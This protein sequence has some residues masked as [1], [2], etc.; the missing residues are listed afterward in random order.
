M[1]ELHARQPRARLHRC[2]LWL[3]QGLIL[4]ILSS[5][6]AAEGSYYRYRDDSGRV[7]IS[8]ILPPDVAPKGY[9]IVDA[10]GRVIS[11][12]AP[13]LT[14][15][16]IAERDARLAREAAEEAARQRQAEADTALLTQFPLPQDAE[17]A[18]ERR[19]TELNALIAFKQS[20][21]TRSTKKAEDLEG[22]AA[23]LEKTGTIVPTAI[24]DSIQRE[25][26]LIEKL[27]QEIAVHESEK[28]RANEEF[29]AKIERLRILTQSAT[30]P[31][32]Q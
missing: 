31:P 25:R 4:A 13:A 28:A 32:L 29:G 17:R 12:V 2:V 10:F 27:E 22:R 30:P 14:P 7:V 18:L 11:T 23:S 21:I 16:Q 3:A 5:P 15:E 26:A 20:T 1:P 24:I 9:Q 8:N 19:L 6:I